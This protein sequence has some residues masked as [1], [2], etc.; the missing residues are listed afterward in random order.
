MHLYGDDS[1]ASNKRES[2][3][4]C[5]KFFFW[6]EPSVTRLSVKLATIKGSLQRKVTDINKG[7]VAV[8]WVL[9]SQKKPSM[10]KLQKGVTDN[11]KES[12]KVPSLYPS[13]AQ[14]QRDGLSLAWSWYYLKSTI[15]DNMCS[16]ISLFN[17]K[18]IKGGSTQFTNILWMQPD[19]STV[20][21]YFG[22]ISA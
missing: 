22:I 21:G 17:T 8:C 9:V 7:M 13:I 19:F 12:K 16:D 6:K 14:R 11:K 5:E 2:Q 20:S 3:L 1:V 4:F 15:W 18:H 10:S